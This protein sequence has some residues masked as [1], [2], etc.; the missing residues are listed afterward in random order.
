VVAGLLA[1]AVTVAAGPAAAELSGSMRLAM[2]EPSL[3]T[4]VSEPPGPPVVV[5][6]DLSDQKMFIYVAEKLSYTFPVSTGRKGYGTPVGKYQAEWLSAKH[7]S[8]KYHWAP[9]PWSVFFHGGYAIHGTTEVRRLGRPASHGCVR[10]H[11]DNAKILYTL[12]RKSGRENTLITVV[13]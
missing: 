6:I 1:A 4:G 13:W 12:I 10:L 3:V 5:R 9:M 11:P 8:R 2:V 7:R